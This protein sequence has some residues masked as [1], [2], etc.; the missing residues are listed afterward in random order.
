M[1]T[2]GTS[3][4]PWNLSVLLVEERPE[5]EAP[6]RVRLAEERRGAFQVEV[7]PRLDRAVEALRV[8]PYD[9]L[10][11][12]LALPQEPSFETLLRARMLAPRLPVVLMTSHPDEELGVQALEAGVQEY[13]IRAGAPP[14]DLGRRLRQAVVR[15]RVAAQK[16]G[17]GDVAAGLAGIAGREPFLR[18]VQETLCLARRFGE[19]PALLLLEVDSW[20]AVEARL[21]RMGQARVLQELGRRLGWCVRRTDA[22]GRLGE[23]RFGVLLANA[24][25]NPALRMVAERL[26]QAA[27]APFQVRGT[28]QRLSVSIGAAWHPQDGDAFEDLLSHAEAAL[29]EACRIGGNRWRQWSGLEVPLEEAPLETRGAGEDLAV[30]AASVWTG[31]SHEA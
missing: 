3:K 9:V 29:L 21:G 20:P 6:V 4:N 12:D 30:A 11:I 1:P 23:E 2:S 5:E 18:R 7:C 22:L 19:R 14:E 15:H 27:A 13:L 26:R 31:L 28:T 24:A 16:R 10:L 8:R 17:G 25:G